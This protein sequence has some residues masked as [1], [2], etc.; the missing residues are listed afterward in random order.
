MW[1]DKHGMAREHDRGT[2]EE[3][4]MGSDAIEVCSICGCPLDDHFELDPYDMGNDD[5]DGAGH[6]NRCGD[7][8]ECFE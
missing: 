7:C 5:L 1:Y 8:A 3:H 6:L 4:Q 2:K